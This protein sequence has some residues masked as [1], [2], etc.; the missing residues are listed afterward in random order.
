MVSILKEI[1]GRLPEDKVTSIEFEGANIVIYTN[2]G[3]FLFEG[4]E[5]IKEIVAE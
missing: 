1:Q 2:D 4:K 3:D 5:K